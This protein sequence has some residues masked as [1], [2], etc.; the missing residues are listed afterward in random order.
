MPDSG[1]RRSSLEKI[2][3]PGRSSANPSV[4]LTE[5]LS[6]YLN[7][8]A[9]ELFPFLEPMEGL[10]GLRLPL[11]PNRFTEND[12]AIALWLGPDEWLLVVPW[13]TEQTVTKT[14]C[15]AG[16]EHFFAITDISHGLTAVNISGPGA[17]D[18]L[19]KGCSLDLHPSVF[20]S[21]CC[22]QTLLAK[23]GVV[24]R[25]VESPHSFDLIVRRSFAEY[26]VLWLQDAGA[27]YGVDL[28]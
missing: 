25:R 11:E 15:Q 12:R 22:A 21:G 26:L 28:L 24:I 3:S 17:I 2:L 6:G 10:S 20:R 4:E 5:K 14:L 18:T 9:K 27:E 7:V 23:A 13:G 16:R 1:L 19:S 8:R